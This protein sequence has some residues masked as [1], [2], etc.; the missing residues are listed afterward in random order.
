M[1][2]LFVLSVLIVLNVF[3]NATHYL[4]QNGPQN[5][6]SPAQTLQSDGVLAIVVKKDTNSVKA[7]HQTQKTNQ[8]GSD[9]GGTFFLIC[10]IAKWYVIC[11]IKSMVKNLTCRLICIKGQK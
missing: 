7:P 1:L 8:S 9:P 11:L 4:K 2:L 5:K 3:L 6:S 10:I